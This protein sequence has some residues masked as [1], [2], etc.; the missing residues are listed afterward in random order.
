DV[1]TH[2]L[3]HRV[4][5]HRQKDV[6]VAGGRSRIPRLPLAGQPEAKT[7]VDAGGDFHR[8]AAGLAHSALAAALGAESAGRAALAAAAGARGHVD[9]LA[10]GGAAGM[11]D[12][13]RAPALGTRVDGRPRLRPG[14]VAAG[15]H[16]DAG[17]HDLFLPT[18][19][20]LGEVD[21]QIVAQIGTPPRRPT[22]R[23]APHLAPEKHIEEIA[24]AAEVAETAEPFK[25]AKGS[26][27]GAA[28]RLGLLERGM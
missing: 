8:Q 10:E 11:P 19:H 25:T 13:P 4:G 21:L 17:H 9:E 5:P 20:R 18:E 24:Q 7:V 15:A 3:E 23:S 28:R 27:A 22:G 12:L 1:V 2:P 6:Q 14:A 16:F 26:A